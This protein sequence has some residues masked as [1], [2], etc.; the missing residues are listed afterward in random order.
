MNRRK[1]R[2]DLKKVDAQTDDDIQ[3]QID[4]DPDL[5]PL[6][7]EDWFR[8]AAVFTLPEKIDVKAIREKTG[9]SQSEFA[10]LIGAQLR[11]LQGW[12]AGRQPGGS[13]C[14]LLRMVDVDPT[15]IARTLEKWKANRQ[16][17]EIETVE[18]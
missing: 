6:A 7:D 4:D 8:S 13:S 2:V 17:K 11:T 12:E 5:A 1:G 3:A 18:R 14:I 10:A 16:Q 9:L 15:I